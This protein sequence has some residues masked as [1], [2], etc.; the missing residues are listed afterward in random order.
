MSRARS[1]ITLVEVVVA[2]SLLSGVLLALAGF[3]YRLAVS[4]S[5]SRVAAIASQLVADRIET[6]K[7]AQRYAS[8]DS[9]FKGTESPVSGFN[10]FDRQ[11]WVT[12]MGGGVTDSVDYRVITVEVRNAR[13]SAPMRKTTIIAA[14]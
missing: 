5:N 7:G 2:M 3:A 1:G 10:G 6:V 4:T 12:H 13:L 14:F 9:L 11:T 8:I